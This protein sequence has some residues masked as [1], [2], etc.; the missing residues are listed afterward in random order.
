MQRRG[1]KIASESIGRRAFGA[2]T[3]RRTHA[4]HIDSDPFTSLRRAV[5]CSVRR[6]A[7][8]G[9]VRVR[10]REHRGGGRVGPGGRGRE[11]SRAEGRAHRARETVA[12]AVVSLQ[13]LG[14][15]RRVRSAAGGVCVRV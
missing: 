7:R 4:A 10:Q 14:R 2:E 5:G 12:L 3:L 1:A 9:G 6:P 8:G 11:A 13:G 15:Q